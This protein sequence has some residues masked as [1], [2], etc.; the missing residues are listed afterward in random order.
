MLGRL[1]GS[2]IRALILSVL[3]LGLVQLGMASVPK[4]PVQ[5]TPNMQNQRLIDKV[6]HSLLML[7]YYGVFDELAFSIEGSNVV[8]TGE[9]TRPVL[10]S[11]AEKAVRD[12][13]GVSNV[14]DNIEVLP[15]SRMDDSIRLAVYRAVFSRPGFEKYADQAIAPIRIIVKNGNI[16][17]DGVVGT[18]FDRVM[19]ETAARSVH[20]AFSV[21]DNLTIG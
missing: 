19:A 5:S 10:K 11:E 14:T 13:P 7:P 1:E 12:V 6:R 17:L 15:L 9:V 20:F 18:E 4:N 16:T 3:F 2:F 8:L 21:T